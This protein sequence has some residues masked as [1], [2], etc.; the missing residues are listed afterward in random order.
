EEGPAPDRCARLGLD[1]PVLPEPRE[2]LA[3]EHMTRE[4]RPEELPPTGEA[5]AKDDS[6]R[7]RVDRAYG[8]DLKVYLPGVGGGATT[9]RLVGEDEVA[10][11]DGDPV[12][13]AGLG[14]KVVR[15]GG[16]RAGR[17]EGGPVCPGGRGANVVRECERRPRRVRDARDELRPQREVGAGDERGGE[18]GLEEPWERGRGQ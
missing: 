3:Q 15:G 14:A 1:D 2:I 18:N 8:A 7:L 9:D 4:H 5:R 11:G 10:R 16:R 12:A 6:D 17:G 13:P